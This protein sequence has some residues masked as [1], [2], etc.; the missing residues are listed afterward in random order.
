MLY[1]G[2][3][4]AIDLHVEVQENNQGTIKWSE[5]NVKNL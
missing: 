4:I 1:L 2:Y 3:C 5:T